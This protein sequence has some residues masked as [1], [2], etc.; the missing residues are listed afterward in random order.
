MGSLSSEFMLSFAG[1]RYHPIR[2]KEQR[3]QCSAGKQEIAPQRY[4]VIVPFMRTPRPT[5]MSTH[6]TWLL[7]RSSAASL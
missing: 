3:E 7:G 5:G 6:C 4:F 1:R 2:N